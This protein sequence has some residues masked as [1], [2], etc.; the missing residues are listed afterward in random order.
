MSCLDLGTCGGPSANLPPVEDSLVEVSRAEVNLQDVANADGPAVEV[1]A[2]AVD[3]VAAH[4]FAA[5]F[6]EA[7]AAPVGEVAQVEA[8]AAAWP[9]PP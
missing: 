1:E 4:M 9:R 8:S 5:M 7:A 6:V 3:E 2:A